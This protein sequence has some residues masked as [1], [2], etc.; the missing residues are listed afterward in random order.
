MFGAQAGGGHLALPAR[1]RTFGPADKLEDKLPAGDLRVFADAQRMGQFCGQLGQIDPAAQLQLLVDELFPPAPVTPECLRPNRA[2]GVQLA[3]FARQ[4]CCRQMHHAAAA[5]HAQTALEARQLDP[6]V[7]QGCGAQHEIGH[8]QLGIGRARVGRLLR[9][10][11][12]DLAGKRARDA[13]PLDRPG[14]QRAQQ[15][16]RQL[17][18][19]ELRLHTRQPMGLVCRLFGVLRRQ[20]RNWWRAPG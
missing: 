14:Q 11:Q 17:L 18:G 15:P 19:F 3:Q 12:L 20:R 9:P 2:P 5:F 6:I 16:Q 10:A 13:R 4:I 8:L 1:R 7:A